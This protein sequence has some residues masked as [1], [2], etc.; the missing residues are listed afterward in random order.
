LPDGRQGRLTEVIERDGRIEALAVLN[1]DAASAADDEA[2]D[3]TVQ[4]SEL[5]LPY[6][7]LGT[8][9]RE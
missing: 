2:R 3:L 9:V 6:S 8:H 5:P 7:L 1:L 4:A